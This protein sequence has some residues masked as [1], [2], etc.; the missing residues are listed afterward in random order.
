MK[1]DVGFPQDDEHVFSMV[2]NINTYFKDRRRRTEMLAY[3]K[4][5]VPGST[6]ETTSLG[7]SRLNTAHSTA[8]HA[9]VTSVTQGWSPKH[10]GGGVFR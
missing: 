5:M 2:K 3:S 9:L 10:T 4:A 7:S 6:L 1:L 8:C